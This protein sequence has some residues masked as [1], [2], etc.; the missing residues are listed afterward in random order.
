MK[1]KH[2]LFMQFNRKMYLLKLI[3][4]NNKYTFCNLIFNLIKGQ[5]QEIISQGRLVKFAF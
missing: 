5:L 1:L 4:P 3:S 2:G